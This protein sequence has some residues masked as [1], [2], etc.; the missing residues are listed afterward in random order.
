MIISRIEQ[1]QF[2]NAIKP[3]NRKSISI[4][5]PKIGKVIAK[6]HLFNMWS[7]WYNIHDDNM[8]KDPACKYSTSSDIVNIV[9]RHSIYYFLRIYEA[10]K[11]R[12]EYLLHH[13]LRISLISQ[14]MGCYHRLS[15]NDIFARNIH[16]YHV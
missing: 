3:L 1:I 4:H 15:D 5:N 7:V 9:F 10:N 16:T 6:P 11:N 2:G 13:T 14:T 8:T 12:K